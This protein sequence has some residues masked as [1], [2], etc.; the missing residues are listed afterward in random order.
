MSYKM[1]KLGDH[2]EIISGYAFKSKDFIESGVPVIKIKNV[3]PPSVSLKDLSFVSEELS[4]SVPKVVLKYDDV[5]IALTGSHI[6]QMA[7]VVGRVARVKYHTKTVM[8]QRVGKIVPKDENDCDLDYVYYYLSQEKIKIMLASKAGGAANQANISPT[9][10]KNV[11]IPFPEIAIQRRIAGILKAYD[12][13]IDKNQQQINLLD[14]SIQRV[15]REWFVDMHY[16]GY[17]NNSFGS[18]ELPEGWGEKS[19]EEL[20]SRV[21]AGGTPSRSKLSYWNEGTFDWFKTGELTDC[22]LLDSEE[23]I[24]E[25]GLK[26]SSAKLFPKD[27]IL[28]AIYASPTLGHLGVFTSEAACNQAALCLLADESIASWQ[29]L[30]CKLYELRDEFNAIAK[31]AGQ[32]NISAETVKKKVVV[33]P[34]KIVMDQFT[35]FASSFFDEKLKLQLQSKQLQEARDRLLPKLM[36]GEIEL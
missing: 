7:S 27:T 29:W 24:S 3:T 4:A 28:M 35:E 34:T 2:V 26:N 23:K 32:Q 16:P 9:D 22:W 8:N 14:E 19:I 21:N 13:L 33:Y 17:K 30:Y 10:V 31:G 5:L 6:N 18:N 36:S 20:C 25:E 1:E 11:I 15:Y 12:D